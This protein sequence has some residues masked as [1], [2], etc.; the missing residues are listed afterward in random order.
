[1]VLFFFMKYMYTF[2]S[3]LGN[4]VFLLIS[5]KFINNMDIMINL[6]KNC[7]IKADPE[8]NFDVDSDS[9]TDIELNF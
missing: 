3:I 1:M 8:A 4:T 9:E 6:D 2:Q 7:L 5:E